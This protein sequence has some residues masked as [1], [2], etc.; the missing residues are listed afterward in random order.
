M[1]TCTGRAALFLGLVAASAAAVPPSITIQ[2][3][4]AAS[5]DVFVY[6]LTPTFNYNTGGFGTFLGTGKTNSGAHDTRTL[7]Q[8]DLSGVPWVPQAVGKAEL[9]V[10]L[11]DGASLFGG[12]VANPLP[13]QGV[14]VSIYRLAAAWDETTVSWSTQPGITGDSLDTIYIDQLFEWRGWDVT[15]A[16]REWLGGNP[17][18]GLRVEQIDV[19]FIDGTE[20]AVFFDSAAASHHPYLK[21]TAH[22]GDLDLDGDVDGT[23]FGAFASCFNG[24]GSPIQTG[25]DAADLNG[26]G[27]VDGTDYGQFSACFNGSGNPPACS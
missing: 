24:T 22:P 20:A 12:A 13:G 21:L 10:Y 7:I 23:D 8:F 11:I 26:D 25:C 4:E 6:R 15:A 5:N 18:Y 3:D 2:P 19:R 17:N 14:N 16:V 1:T 27:S 9:V